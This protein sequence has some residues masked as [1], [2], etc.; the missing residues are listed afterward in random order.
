MKLNPAEMDDPLRSECLPNTRLDLIGYIHHWASTPNPEQ[1]I[2]WLHGFPGAGKSTVATSVANLFR[3]Q[4]RLG[5]FVFFTRSAE[6]RSDPA[7]LIRTVAYQL[8]EFDPRIC[9]EISR[10]LEEI[11]SIKQAPLR[12]QFQTLL[13]DPLVSL[14]NFRHEWVRR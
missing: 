13:I 6:A 1:N 2:F 10:V 14:H 5:A 12:W 8:G 3:E 4:R 11:P 9:A 7:F